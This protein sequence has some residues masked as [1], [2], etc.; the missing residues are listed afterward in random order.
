MMVVKEIM[1]KKMN[2]AVATTMY[3]AYRITGMEK[4]MLASIQQQN[5]VLWSNYCTG[6]RISTS[7]EN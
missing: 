3:P 6:I 1:E 2:A 5:A 7:P 4:R